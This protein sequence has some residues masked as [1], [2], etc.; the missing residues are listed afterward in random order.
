V[1][2][3]T[4]L[5]QLVGQSL[6]DME[7]PDPSNAPYRLRRCVGIGPLALFFYIKNGTPG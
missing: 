5:A 1:E 7:L 2:Q 4:P 3:P 6:P